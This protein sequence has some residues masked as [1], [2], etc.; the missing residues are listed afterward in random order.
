[1]MEVC[2]VG[3]FEEV[4]KNMTAVKIKDDVIIFD[5]GL[6]LPAVIEQQE[7]ETEQ[8]AYSEKMLRGIHAI[9]D[10]LVLD[11]L[12]WRDKVRAII[13]GHAHLDHIGAIPYI[14]D[15][16]PKAEILATPFTMA[17]LESILADEKIRL[18]N[19]KKIIRAGT[20]YTIKGKGGTYK[21]EF[22][23]TTHSTIQC[24]L[25]ALHTNEGIFFYGLD[26]KFD[27]YPTLGDPPKYKKLRELGR[28]GI[29]V[30]VLDSLYSGVD[31]KT[32]SERIARHLLEDA[33]SSVRDRKCALIVTTFSSHIAR[34]KS[35]VEFGKKT[36]RKIVFLGRSLN[37]YVNAAIKVGQCPFRKDI[38]LIKYRKQV[39]SMLRRIGKDRGKYMVVCTGHQ[40]EP[41]SILDRIVK[42]ETPLKLKPRDNII[43]SSSVIPAPANINARDRMDKKLRRKGVRVQ[44]DIHV[45]GH[46]G[47]EDL[48]DLMNLLKPKHL[49]PAHGSLQQETPMIELASELGYKF[50]ETSHLSSNG[51]VLKF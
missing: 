36:N 29:K 18:R 21:A 44:T 50:G 33:L 39:D 20:T 23:H 13:I 35:I 10:D 14:A 11:K 30:L 5:A 28:R 16:Y 41:G 7:E 6:Y 9:P 2:T 46:A 4:G 22:I 15:R 27:N 47:R 34:L 12:G 49:I 51:K 25:V 17:I 8:T 26:F 42:E 48:R 19:P 31:R 32:A 3:G 38:E 1:M 45:S 24:V 40:A 43:F 37:K